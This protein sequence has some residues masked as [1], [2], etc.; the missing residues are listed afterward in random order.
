MFSRLLKVSKINCRRSSIE[1][2]GLQQHELEVILKTKGIILRK[3]I[4]SGLKSTM[5][6]LTQVWTKRATGPAGRQRVICFFFSILFLMMFL[7][8]WTGPAGL[9]RV[10]LYFVIILWCPA[11]LFLLSKSQFLEYFPYQQIFCT[12]GGYNS[13]AF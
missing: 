4:K 10:I 7:S 1:D 8:H 2:S 12:S 11:L 9:Q 3:K 6:C 5:P 13:K